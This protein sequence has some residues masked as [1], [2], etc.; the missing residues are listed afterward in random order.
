MQL[1]L[2]HVSGVEL[3]Y[4]KAH[5]NVFKYDKYLKISRI[6]A[7]S[8]SNIF[9]VTQV[10]TSS[11]TYVLRF[12]FGFLLNNYF[13]T[14]LLL[15][16]ILELV[17][18]CVTTKVF[19]SQLALILDS[20]KYLSYLKTLSNNSEYWIFCYGLV[21]PRVGVVSLNWVNNWLCC[22]LF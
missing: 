6:R 2:K 11:E 18:T 17:Q 9:V 7:S 5:L 3:L 16:K 20:F 12:R 1:K 15:L 8:E 22:L 13:N 14:P 19:N 10:C 21:S 4:K